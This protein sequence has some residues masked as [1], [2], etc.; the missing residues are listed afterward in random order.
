M[1]WFEKKSIPL[2]LQSLDPHSVY[3][4]PQDLA[5]R[6]ESEKF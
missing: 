3:L 2:I 5:E 4:P 6:K 1:T